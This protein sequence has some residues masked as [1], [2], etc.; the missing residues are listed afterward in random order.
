MSV[1][2]SYLFTF[3]NITTL[4]GDDL[5]E[6]YEQKMARLQQISSAGYTVEVECKCQFDKNILPHYPELKKHPIIQHTPLNTRDA[7]YEGR[8]E[9]IVLHYA[10][11]VVK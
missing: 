6:R 11:R 2:R 5:A 10:I 9:A 1:P 3:R 7:L 4:G 8:T